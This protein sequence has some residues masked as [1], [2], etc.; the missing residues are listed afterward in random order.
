[1]I[2]AVF[3]SVGGAASLALAWALLFT[4]G[5]SHGRSF[6]TN[7]LYVEYEISRAGVIRPPRMEFLVVMDGFPSAQTRLYSDGRHQFTFGYQDGDSL[8]FTVQPGQTV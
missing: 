4:G 3:L 7:N 6:V 2:R 8:A 1:M 5:D